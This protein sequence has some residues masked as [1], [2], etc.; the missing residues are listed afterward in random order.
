M[1][2]ARGFSLIEVLLA[3]LVMAIGV[4][5]ILAL[6]LVGLRA[7]R[8]TLL[9][10]SAVRLATD[11]AEQVGGSTRSAALLQSFA[12]FDYVATDAVAD[13]SATCYGVDSNCTPDQL[14]GFITHQWQERLRETLPGGRV[15]ICRDTAPWQAANK[16]M[17]WECNGA[18]DN[19]DVTSPLWI[20]VGWRTESASAFPPSAPQVV[21]PVAA[22][23]H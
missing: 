18:T 6:Q 3:L 9:Q 14:A 13:N 15:R 22:F 2:Q 16:S 11:I 19:N 17:R 5:G 23:A 10:S 12:Q 20:K 21:L 4:L 8:D 1:L 7:T